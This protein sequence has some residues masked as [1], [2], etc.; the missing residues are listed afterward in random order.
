[1]KTT[2]E[3]KAAITNA[4]AFKH[5]HPDE[6]ATTAAR[7]HHVNPI[8]VRSNLQRAQLPKVKHGGQN[9]ML[10]DT[11]VEAIYK[12]VEDSYLSGYGATKAMVYAAIGCLKANQL[13]AKEPPSWRWFQIFMKE[14]PD[15]F[16]TLKTKAIARVH[17]TA[18]DVEEVKDWFNGFRTW[19][20]EHDIQPRD[21]LNF[22]EAGFRVG[23]ALGEEI[24]VPTYVKEV[25]T[26][27]RSC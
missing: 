8:T 21:V 23:V 5:D 14:H 26:L 10:S 7:I 3:Y 9:K 15:L 19:C 16:R 2:N 11:Q 20:K 22:D 12:Y 1:M 4:V 13:P 6:K 25:S 24:V 18:A 27:L 17:V